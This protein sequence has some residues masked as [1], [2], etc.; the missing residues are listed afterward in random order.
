MRALSREIS[1]S[2]SIK[3]DISEEVI[4]KLNRWPPMKMPSVRKEEEVGKGRGWKREEG[5]EGMRDWG[6]MHGGGRK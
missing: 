3:S 4:L 6:G 1:I 2:S 5:W